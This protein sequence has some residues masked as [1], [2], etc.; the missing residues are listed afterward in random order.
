MEERGPGRRAEQP[1]AEGEAPASREIRYGGNENAN[2]ARDANNDE[3]LA[4]KEGAEQ[5]PKAHGQ[6]GF[7]NA[8]LSGGAGREEGGKGG[9]GDC[10]GEKDKGCRG[11]GFRGQAVP[12]IGKVEGREQAGTEVGSNAAAKGSEQCAGRGRKGV[13]H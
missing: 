1:A 6:Q 8:E 7:R 5:T 12:P 13:V 3:G 10:L 9:G 4:R 11:E 2:R